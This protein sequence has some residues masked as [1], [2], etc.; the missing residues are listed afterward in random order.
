MAEWLKIPGATEGRALD[1]VRGNLHEV[2][3]THPGREDLEELRLAPSATILVTFEMDVSGAPGRGSLGT[4]A[5]AEATA[6]FETKPPA[7]LP[8]GSV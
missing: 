5:Q 4:T 1:E 6:A 8:G 3:E 2:V 7:S